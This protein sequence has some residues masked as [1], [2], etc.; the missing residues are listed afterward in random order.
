MRNRT[1][2]QIE[3]ILIRHGETRSNRERRYLGKTDEPLSEDGKK[4]LEAAKREGIYPGADLVCVSPMKRCRETADI[5]YP[6][7]DRLQHD[8]EI[9]PEWK[10]TDFGEFEGKN[11]TE[12]CHD[13]RYQEWIDSGGTLP[14]PGG[15]SRESFCRRCETGFLRVLRITGERKGTEGTRTACIVHGG[16]IMAVLSRFYGGEY[17]DYQVPNGGGYRFLVKTGEDG[18]EI[19]DL[20]KL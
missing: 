5:L 9:V 11:Y 18:P 1:E 13:R 6:G 7:R 2:D 17:F 8:L 12:L 15:E 10:E 4:R 19:T 20:E 14:F 16:T 3:I